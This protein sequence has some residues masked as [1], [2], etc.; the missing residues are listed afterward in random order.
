M[1]IHVPPQLAANLQAWAAEAGYADAESYAIY[2]LSSGRGP[3]ISPPI[4]PEED[5]RMREIIAESSA[6][7][8]RN[9]DEHEWQRYRKWVSD[10]ANLPSYSS[11]EELKDLLNAADV[12]VT[13]WTDADLQN[14]RETLEAFGQRSQKSL[15]GE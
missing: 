5:A 8:I 9:M 13:D 11:R 4:S 2:L 14:I 12:E 10:P 15:G 6:V 7:T 1:I 3:E